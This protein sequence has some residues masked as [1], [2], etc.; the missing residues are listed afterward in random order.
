MIYISFVFRCY[1]FFNIFVIQFKKT[2][3]FAAVNDNLFTAVAV[4]ICHGDELWRIASGVFHRRPKCAIAV[5]YQHR[6][7]PDPWRRFASGSA[8][9]NFSSGMEN[10]VVLPVV[11]GVPP[12]SA[13]ISAMKDLSA[14]P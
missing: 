3:R 8:A 14:G 7:I 12:A 2:L 5:P 4:Q 13:I 10:T 6:R 9:T 11:I 1:D